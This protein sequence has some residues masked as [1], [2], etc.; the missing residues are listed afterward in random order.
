MNTVTGH[1]QNP[2]IF[3]QVNQSWLYDYATT[4]QRFV[5]FLLDAVILNRIFSM[6]AGFLMGVV[7]VLTGND[8]RDFEIFTN[9]VYSA[10]F[11]YA[12]GAICLLVSYTIIE[13]ASKGRSL[14]KLITK[15]EAV[16]ED[17]SELTYNDAFRRA[18]CRI[19][20]FEPF[21]ALGGYPWHDTWTGT[22]VVK[23]KFK[24][25]V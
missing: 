10:L 17:G 14:G 15:T 24:S 4:S 8:P 21:S 1:E 19:I 22:V 3:D 13:G 23:R 2:S 7:I 12:V 18:L 6:I 25:A 16:K 20:P 5:N 11:N 9:P